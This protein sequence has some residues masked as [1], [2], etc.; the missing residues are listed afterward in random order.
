M[1]LELLR[2]DELPDANW[3]VY[4]FGGADLSG[5]VDSVKALREWAAHLR[6]PV[7]IT[8][9]N[10]DDRLLVRAQSHIDGVRVEIVCLALR[11]QL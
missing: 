7:T 11:S 6:A 9:V 2:H 4:C 3:S 10:N 5:L 1:L 8:P